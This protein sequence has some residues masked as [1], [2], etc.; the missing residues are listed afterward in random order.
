MRLVLG[1]Q[2]L[3]GLVVGDG[4]VDVALDAAQGEEGVHGHVVLLGVEM[5]GIRSP[6]SGT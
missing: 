6:S 3:D 2:V 1:V 5:V 4:V